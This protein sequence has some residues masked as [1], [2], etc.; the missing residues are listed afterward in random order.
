MSFLKST[1]YVCQWLI[2]FFAS[3]MLMPLTL[4]TWSVNIVWWIILYPYKCCCMESHVRSHELRSYVRTP[5]RSH[6]LW[7]IK[8]PYDHVLVCGVP[9]FFF[10]GVLCICSFPVWIL[11]SGF[12]KLFD[13]YL[14]LY[15]RNRPESHTPKPCWV[16][17]KQTW[18]DAMPIINDSTSER[19]PIINDVENYGTVRPSSSESVRN[20]ECDVCKREVSG[21]RHIVVFNPCGHGSCN[22]CSRQLSSCHICRMHIEN[23][24]RLFY[25]V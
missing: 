13:L 3:S 11:I 20:R 1:L 22:A 10:S 9:K 16:P 24:I 18:M 5:V 25:G 4:I 14:V 6:E 2:I 12:I 17:F 21:R 8:F 15:Y 19:L 23:R 7:P